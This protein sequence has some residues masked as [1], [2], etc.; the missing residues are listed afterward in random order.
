M[1]GEASQEDDRFLIFPSTA[2][3]KRN[4][5]LREMGHQQFLALDQQLKYFAQINHS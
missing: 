2:F 4:V 3:V 1:T 5:T